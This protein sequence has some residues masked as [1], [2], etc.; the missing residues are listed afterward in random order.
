MCA[1]WQHTSYFVNN[2]YNSIMIKEYIWSWWIKCLKSIPCEKNWARRTMTMKRILNKKKKIF[3]VFLP[4]YF[5]KSN[6]NNVSSTTAIV[7][8]KMWNHSI[9][10]SSIV[11]SDYL[12]WREQM[13]NLS[14][15]RCSECL[16]MDISWMVNF[17]MIVSGY[18]WST[19][20]QSDNIQQTKA[21]WLCVFWLISLSYYWRCWELIIIFLWVDRRWETKPMSSWI[22]WNQNVSQNQSVLRHFRSRHRLSKFA[23]Y[24]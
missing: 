6:L 21:I 15:C 8:I 24:C 5:F 18:R 7:W 22:N 9:D 16:L 17:W 23:L 1:F 2:F 10:G 12:S 4:V 14:H 13:N 3:Q 19:L 11:R 20:S